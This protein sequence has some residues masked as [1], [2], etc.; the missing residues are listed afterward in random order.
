MCHTIDHPSN[1]FTVTNQLAVIVDVYITNL[2]VSMLSF[3]N[4]TKRH[5]RQVRSGAEANTRH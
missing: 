1:H 5:A 4:E 2:Y 3:Q